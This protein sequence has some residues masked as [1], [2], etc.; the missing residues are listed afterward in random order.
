M[1]PLSSDSTWA[2]CA[3]TF[4][5]ISRAIEPRGS[6]YLSFNPHQRA[7]CNAEVIQ[8]L[9]DSD[10]P[11]SFGDVRRNRDNRPADLA[12]QAIQLFF[13]P[14]PRPRTNLLDQAHATPHHLTP[15]RAPL[16][17]TEPCTGALRPLPTVHS[18]LFTPPRCPPCPNR[19]G[20]HVD[21]PG[22]RPGGRRRFSRRSPA[23]GLHPRAPSRAGCHARPA[24]W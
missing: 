7:I 2:A 16:S 15:D 10:V 6:H 14:G 12:C 3:R 11:P 17:T 13:R 21:R 1:R 20:S 23:P 24:G 18:P 4:S 9:L 5:A 19:P 22:P 8:K